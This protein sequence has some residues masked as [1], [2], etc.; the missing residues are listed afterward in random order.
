MNSAMEF[1]PLSPE[2]QANPYPYYEMLRSAAPVFYWEQWGMWFLTRYD[3]CSAVLRSPHFGH[4]ITK[5]M[6]REELGWGAEPPET[7][8]PLW[9]MQ[10]QWMLLKDPPDHSRLRTLVHKA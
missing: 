10:R 1:N 7:T 5:H 2:F 6:T 8:M 3:D 4:E 9:S